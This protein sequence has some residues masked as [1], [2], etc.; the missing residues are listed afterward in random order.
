MAKKIE[1]DRLDLDVD[2]LLDLENIKSE[3][4]EEADSSLSDISE[5]FCASNPSSRPCSGPS[6]PRKL[7]LNVELIDWQPLESL[8]TS[9]SSRIDLNMSLKSELKVLNS[10]RNAH[11]AWITRSLNKLSDAKENDTLT[12][13]LFNIKFQDAKSHLDKIM[14][15]E[16]KIAM[17]FDEHNVLATD[18]TRMNHETEIVT[19]VDEVQ[20]TLAEYEAEFTKQELASGSSGSSRVEDLGA[21][22]IAE[23]IKTSNSG[24]SKLKLDCPNFEGNK[25]DKFHYKDWI[26][27]FNNVISGSGNVSNKLKLQYLQSKCIGEAG[28][29][30]QHLELLNDN[31]LVA[32]NILEKHYLD[33]ALIRDE[34]IEHILTLRP[35][36]DVEYTKTKMYL[37]EV[38]N[39]VNDLKK[40]Y[41]ADLTADEN[42][43]HSGG[44]Y[45]L[46]HVVFSKLSTELKKA[47]ILKAGTCFPTFNQIFDLSNEVINVINK[48]RKK[49][50][51]N[52]HKKSN[53]SSTSNDN[54]TL[55]FATVQLN[56]D[57]SNVNT[58]NAVNKIN[59]LPNKSEYH[60]RLCN[61]NGHSTLYCN[62]YPSFDTRKARCI[63]L[64][65]CYLCT[66][67]THKAD[68]CHGKT[69]KLYIVC[70][71]CNKNTH[72]SAMCPVRPPIA[73][74]KAS[75]Y[76]CL[77]TAVED[78]SSFLLPVISIIMEGP[79]G[80]WLKFNALMDTCSSRTYLSK[81]I[82]TKLE[83]DVPSLRPVHYEV[84]TFLGQ[85]NK[86]F[87]DATVQ[88][89]YSEG[90]FHV[91]PVLVDE[92]FEISMKVKNLNIAVRN[93]KD[94]G[95]KLSG[96]FTDNCDQVPI[97]ALVGTDVLQFIG[98]LSVVNCLYGKAF[99]LGSGIVPFGNVNHFLYPNQVT[100]SL[101]KTENNYKTIINK[102]NC[103][104]LY[105]N[106]VLEPKLIYE[107]PLDHIFNESAV[108]RR[109]DKMLSCESL[110]IND[111]E[112]ISDYDQIQ[113]EKFK[114]GIELINGK[115]NVELVWNDNIDL[116]PSNH[117]LC[118]VALDKTMKRLEK[119]GFDEAY[120]QYW[121]DQESADYIER[122]ECHPSEYHNYRWLPH[123]PVF[124][125][126]EQSTT[127]IRGV[128]NASFKA[129]NSPSL[130]EASYCGINIMAD[131]CDLLLK[132]RTN[133][134]VLLGDLKHA[135]LQ[136]KL[137]YLKDRNNFCFFV[138]DGDELVCYR[139]KTIIFGFNSS[140]FMLN[141]VIKNIA[142]RYPDDE[143]SR[144]IKSSFFV[145]NLVYT[146]NDINLLTKLYKTSVARLADNGFELRSCNTNDD[147]LRSL[148]KGDGKL[149]E[150]TCEFDKVLGYRYSSTRD[151]M[152]LSEVKLNPFAN[153]K[154]MI[155]SESSKVFDPLSLASPVT[156][157]GKTLVSTI[158]SQHSPS[159][160]KDHWDEVVSEEIVREW[161]SLSQDLEKLS[162]VEFP[163]YSLSEDIMGDLYVFCDA[164][165]SAYG[166]AAY[167]VQDGQSHLI[168][169]KV[170]VAPLKTKTL[171]TLELLSVFLAFK[172]LFTLL[173]NFS[174]IIKNVFIGI[175]AQVVLTW[176]LS[177]SIKTKSIYTKNRVRN[178]HEMKSQLEEK[179]QI[180]FHFK[181][182][183]TSQNPADLLTRGLKLEKFKDNLLFWI[184]GPS[185][186]SSDPVV[187]PTSDLM[188][189][190]SENKSVVL[191]TMIS[192]VNVEPII[193][194]K[195]YGKLTKLVSIV[196]KV[197]D[198]LRWKKVI[199]DIHM[200]RWWGTTDSLQGAKMN[201]IK[202]MQSQSFPIE[203]EF[204]L[205]PK[206]KDIP[207]LVK[208]ANLF[209]DECGVVRSDGR[210]GKTDYFDYEVINPI[211]LPKDHVLSRLIIE[212]AHLEVKHLGI[213]ATLNHLRL[214]GFW[215]VHP[216]QSVKNVIYP[217]LICK[218]FNALSY[219]YPKVTNL[220]KHRVNLV[221]PYLHVGV[222]FT[223]HIMIK[224]GKK[225]RK[226]YLLLFTCLNIRAIHMEL[227]PDMS[228][229]QFVLAFVRFANLYGLPTHIYSDNAKSF[230]AGV[231]H[232][233]AVFASSEFLE[234]FSIYNIKHIT[235][236]LYAPWI[237]AVWERMI[238]T[239]KICL[240]KT[241]G[242]IKPT[243]FR[244][245][246]ILSDIQHTI[247]SRPLTYRC[248][249]EVGLDV[250]TPNSFLR[251][252]ALSK[253]YLKNPESPIC[254]LPKKSQLYK[255]IEVR[256]KMLE[257]F[258]EVWYNE[259][260]LGLRL[261]HKDLHQIKFE[262]KVKIG[263]IVL[264]KNPAK[265]RQHWRLGKILELIPGSDGIVRAVKLFK[266][267]SDYIANPQVVIHSIKHLYP[268]ELSLT[269]NVDETELSVDDNV[270]VVD[271]S[272]DSL[273]DSP[274]I[275]LESLDNMEINALNDISHSRENIDQDMSDDEFT[276]IS[277]SLD[278]EP[279]SNEPNFKRPRRRAIAR[280]RPLDNDFIYYE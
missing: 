119:S 3:L 145:D 203:I 188:C 134:N 238:K 269:H 83:F 156:V 152:K 184:K 99:Q 214:A 6:T 216:Y 273:H 209:I 18:T 128:F 95:Y 10:S 61:I 52:T 232:I 217:C 22:A 133:K 278:I 265:K 137:K 276:A 126:D 241:I 204:L 82:A 19:Y 69:N 253:I 102:A 76:V 233:S 144:M 178:I 12:R 185:W 150:H 277:E 111:N 125:M 64:K 8:N 94:L 48:T 39:I 78:C 243:Y 108:E 147:T 104:P 190:S 173:R 149:I 200:M 93:F 193:S 229:G 15:I 226:Y 29:F 81:E 256:D 112:P 79:S 91:L 127:K 266:A 260:L 60:C 181:Y 213:Q 53:T 129:G 234:T 176:V 37:A 257:D 136:I 177:D 180:P 43:N 222:D 231:N 131:M 279:S 250:L 170:K 272:G 66:S 191:N 239:V 55:N 258:K 228:T 84:K 17:L 240:Q 212:H 138:K 280:G 143:C 130:N 65:L 211:L 87:K 160:S 163:R 42:G 49:N 171:P 165:K 254:T 192:K 31:Y 110:G 124:K 255:S 244:L 57:N 121:R 75:R 103:P 132:F 221:R 154:R 162:S 30:I 13:N 247:N 26:R 44:Y 33:K 2:D 141:Y 166:Y 168:F 100:Q 194:F 116:V 23:A 230:I 101:S 16:N 85:Q 45:V 88:V 235:I 63:D 220:P 140:P 139:Y 175:D 263:D 201:L 251:P 210:I 151:V 70:R 27:K 182:V 36:Y 71:Y 135:F 169:S 80:A 246:T 47:I 35:E 183:P 249:E 142:D 187:W 20:C 259:Y 67:M 34:L 51:G 38:S 262:N 153:T 106:Q 96:E 271:E 113:I 62:A 270:E 118:L 164:A 207:A 167:V 90:N 252:H 248:S 219:R 202:I 46:S 197:I 206:N 68:D 105:V 264:I 146:D 97:H 268:L 155:L 11:K 236:P 72:C 14:D 41:A 28:S 227:L 225:E 58:S 73:T 242:R 40:H 92:S 267:D 56:P 159:S 59:N 7:N 189:L 54:S 32:I 109:I 224:D 223:G 198:L 179:Y 148:M 215:L 275:D 199:K 122:F 123:R 86:V 157:S 24:F 74:G 245:L 114:N 50:S 274:D 89:H 158:W 186:L 4:S 5:L 161:T 208:S 107:D 9:T 196:S 117:N 172:G 25:K 1:L 261:L 237:G 205:N 218:K 21:R 77:S 98:D 174:N 120:N 115:V 195:R